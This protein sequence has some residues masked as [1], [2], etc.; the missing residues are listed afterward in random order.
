M[1]S[2]EEWIIKMWYIYTMKHYSLFSSKKTGIMKFTGKWVG[3]ETIIVGEVTQT[4]K[5]KTTCFLSVLDVFFIW[6]RMF[7]Y[8]FSFFIKSFVLVI[9]S[10]PSS[11]LSPI[12]KHI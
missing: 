1:E 3:L 9:L 11:T 2:A 5:D 10:I 6:S 4:Q 8:G 12:P 7:S